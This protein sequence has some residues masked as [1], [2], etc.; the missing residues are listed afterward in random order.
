MEEK[1]SFNSELDPEVIKVRDKII[2]KIGDKPLEEVNSII[3]KLLN[4]SMDD[5]TRLGALAARLKI[6]R[7]KIELLYEKKVDIKPAETKKQEKNKVEEELKGKTEKV[8]E[9]WVRVKMLEPSEVNGKQID[10]GVILDV[11]EDDSKKL[12]ETKKAEIVQEDSDGAAP[13]EK[14]K[15]VEESNVNDEKKS[16]KKT[17]QLESDTEKKDKE[18]K[19][20]KSETKSETESNSETG[21]E[22]EDKKTKNLLEKHEDAVSDDDKTEN[23][24]DADKTLEEKKENDLEKSKETSENKIKSESEVPKSKDDPSSTEND[25]ETK[26]GSSR[27]NETGNK[28]KEILPDDNKA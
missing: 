5:V 24:K 3:K 6:I 7:S 25:V 15:S 27:E 14:N 2:S 13:I 1:N 20:P 26:E 21:I 11:K 17:E 12:L 4:E 19:E 22:E 16:V 9:K 18:N 10:K 8:E 28:D 23:K